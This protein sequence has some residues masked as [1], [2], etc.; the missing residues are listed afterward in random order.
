MGSIV[1]EMTDEELRTKLEE[2]RSELRE[3]RFTFAVAR[4][5][6]SPARFKQLKRE[7]ARMET[8]LR[9][10]ELG[11]SSQKPKSEKKKK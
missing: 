3:L 2:N 4:S 11:I 10:R 7:V 9:E 1:H 5:V 6:Q 8:V